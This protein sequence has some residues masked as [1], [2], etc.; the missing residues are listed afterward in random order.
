[1]KDFAWSLGTKATFNQLRSTA[2]DVR[3]PTI[4]MYKQSP[5]AACVYSGAFCRTH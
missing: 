1:M 5:S 2:R 3:E 4:E